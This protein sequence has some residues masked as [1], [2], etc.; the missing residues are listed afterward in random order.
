M[1]SV[2]S[3]GPARINQ[4]VK[5]DKIQKR[6][7]KWI[8][9]NST[10]QGDFVSKGKYRKGNKV[11]VWFTSIDNTNYQKDVYR[12]DIIKT[13]IFHPNG[14]TK[15]K[16]QSTTE[17]TDDFIH[18]FY[19]GDWKHYNEKGKLIYIKKYNRGKPLDSISYHY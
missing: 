17:V 7:G 5:E 13:R 2:V 19:S 6:N 3:C 1:V 9:T 14:K 10:E 4:Y 11:G 18:W 12:K 15:I 16:G 8:E